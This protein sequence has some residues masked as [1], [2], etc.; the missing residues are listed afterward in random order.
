MFHLPFELERSN[1]SFRCN[2]QELF[3][4]ISFETDVIMLAGLFF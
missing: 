1:L 2:F 3:T 4:S